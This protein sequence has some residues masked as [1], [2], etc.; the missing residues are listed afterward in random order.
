MIFVCIFGYSGGGGP[1]KDFLSFRVNDEVSVDADA[2]AYPP[3][4]IH[5]GMQ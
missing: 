5:T 3:E 4:Y 1:D 2:E